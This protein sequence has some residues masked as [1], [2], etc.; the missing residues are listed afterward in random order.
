MPQS[1]I[2]KGMT[3]ETIGFLVVILLIWANEIVDLPHRVLGAPE[4]GPYLRLEEAALES[5]IV[6]LVGLVAIYL[7]FRSLRRIAH[8]ESFLR[9]CAWCRRVETE[10]GW[11]PVETYLSS[12]GA[13]TTHGICPTCV[14]EVEGE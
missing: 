2:D 4:S 7:R 8:L 12:H 10:E 13:E 6:A 11:V 14:S 9:L 3:F 1:L 5:G